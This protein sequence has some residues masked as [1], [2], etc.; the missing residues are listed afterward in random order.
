LNEYP[1]GIT[2][3]TTEFFTPIRSSLRMICGSTT[4]EDA[5][6][7]H[8]GQ[9]LPQ[10]AEELEDVQTEARKIPPST[11]MTKIATDT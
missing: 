9:F 4:S 6:A 7:E 10:I 5:V 11:T 2:R 1:V 3:P 8:D